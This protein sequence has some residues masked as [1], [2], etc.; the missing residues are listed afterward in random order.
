M[1]LRYGT[2][3]RDICKEI[4]IKIHWFVKNKKKQSFMNQFS[5]SDCPDSDS[6]SDHPGAVSPRS[7]NSSSLMILTVLNFHLPNFRNIRR[8]SIMNSS[9]LSPVHVLMGVNSNWSFMGPLSPGE[10]PTYAPLLAT[11]RWPS[12]FDDT[13]PA[14]HRT[15][16][17]V[18]L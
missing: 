12:L 16:L 14:D 18:W 2:G 6:N 5:L 4:Y 10:A 13:S 9:V 17:K 3:F 1:L 15:L 8:P 7:L 11:I